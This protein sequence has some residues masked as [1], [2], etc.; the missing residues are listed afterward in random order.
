L[1]P[2]ETEHAAFSV[3]SR[4]DLSKNAGLS[5]ARFFV[6]LFPIETKSGS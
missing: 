6:L 5:C 3:E 1:T 4:A 2:W